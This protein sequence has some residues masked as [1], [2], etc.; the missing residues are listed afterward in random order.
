MDLVASNL[1]AMASSHVGVPNTDLPT[2][3][4]PE[5]VRSDDAV[6][7]SRLAFV[8]FRPSLAFLLPVDSEA[9]PKT[10]QNASAWGDQIPRN[11]L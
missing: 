8:H 4:R 5:P 2:P 6:A 9:E 1:L 11:F 3:W 10:K 7:S